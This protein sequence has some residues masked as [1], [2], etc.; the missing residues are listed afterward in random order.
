MVRK[1]RFGFLVLFVLLTLSLG[2]Q[3]CSIALPGAK[4]PSCLKIGMLKVTGS[5]VYDPSGTFLGVTIPLKRAGRLILVEGIIDNI[6]GNLILDTGAEEL[7]LNKTYFRN[8]STTV[9][10]EA[11]GITGTAGT[12]EKTRISTLR[13]SEITVNG[14]MTDLAPLGHLENRRGVKI[15]GLLGMAILK[16]YEMVL[17]VEGNELQI[18]RTDRNGNRLT[19]TRPAMKFDQIQKLERHRNIMFMTA[20]IAGRPLYFC[21]DTGAESNVINLGAPKKVL[22]TVTITR[23]S[24]LR[25]VGSGEK[26]VLYGILN[27]FMVGSRK[28]GP[29]ETIL[30]DLTSMS[31]YYGTRIDGML[32]FDFFRKGKFSFNLVKREIGICFNKE[33]P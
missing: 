15:L 23:R 17:D 13:F 24:T 1:L 31:D 19:T 28:I 6:A 10:R 32:G 27:D 4:A 29:M 2:L 33:Q 25:G 30:T 8:Y 11:G 16:E 5:P 12:V 3:P 18:Y 7:V 9:S 26:E 14:V 21:L 20:N 22:S